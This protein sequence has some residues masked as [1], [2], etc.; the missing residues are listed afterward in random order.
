MKRLIFD[1]PNLIFRV[2]AMNQDKIKAS[3]INSELN[4]VDEAQHQLGF[5]LHVALS[6]MLKHYRIHKPDQVAVVFEGRQNWRKAYTQSAAS[7]SKTVYKAN[8]VRD[9]SAELL[10]ELIDNFRELV[11]HHTSIVTLHC[12][13][14]EGDDLIAGYTQRFTGEG[15]EV[16][17][18][19]S[20]KD[21]MQ[22]YRLPNVTLINPDTGKDRLLETKFKDFDPIWYLF[23]KCMRGDGGDNVPSAKPRERTTRIRAAFEDEYKKTQLMN[24]TWKIVDPDDPLNEEKWQIF[25]VGDLF[26]ENKLLVDL[27]EQ[28]PEIR[29]LIDETLD[30]ELAV[31]GKW[32][33]FHF[34]RW[35]GKYGLN[36]V[37]DNVT[38]YADM[39]AAT[40]RHASDTAIKRINRKTIS[41][42]V[43]TDNTV[44]MSASEVLAHVA[45]NRRADKVDIPD[46]PKNSLIEF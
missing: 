39:F 28:P 19:S 26:D 2:F 31:Q 12:D 25:R 35:C 14:L 18:V 37:S 20:D 7:V 23:E 43:F 33:M 24:D 4:D 8:R 11:T 10:F 17:I 36:Q 15:D 32:N 41:D 34:L 29:S 27:F 46:T 6:S 30:K 44:T 1:T 22:L 13:Y 42:N 45:N 3:T 5:C 16:V 21:F 9:P 38:N 40:G